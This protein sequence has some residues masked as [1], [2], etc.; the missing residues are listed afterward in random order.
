MCKQ[1]WSLKCCTGW[2]ALECFLFL[3]EYLAAIA[4]PWLRCNFVSH[5][6]WAC[7]NR[8]W[9]ALSPVCCSWSASFYGISQSG[10]RLLWATHSHYAKRWFSTDQH[11]RA[12]RIHKS[13]ISCHRWFWAQT[14][15]AMWPCD[16]PS[17]ALESPD[18]HRPRASSV[19]HSPSCVA[20]QKIS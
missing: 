10:P 4:V 1:K 3:C 20:G 18:V 17:R 13:Q 6:T 5:G 19:C 2:T 7:Q 14:L 9:P 12:H 11:A 8:C 16:T 15:R